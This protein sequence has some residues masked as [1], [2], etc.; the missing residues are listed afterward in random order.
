MKLESFMLSER[1]QSQKNTYHSIFKLNVQKRK[2]IE[3]ENRL[4]VAQNWGCREDK[5]ES[6]G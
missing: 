3:I 6:D 5:V 4:S 2:S 1:S